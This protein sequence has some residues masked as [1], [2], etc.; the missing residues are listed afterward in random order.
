LP[1]IGDVKASLDIL[2]LLQ[3]RWYS[4]STIIAVDCVLVLL[5]LLPAYSTVGWTTSEPFKD[6]FHPVVL[7]KSIPLLFAAVIL[8]LIWGLSVQP[9]SVPKYKI[10][11]VVAIRTENEIEYVRIK[12]DFVQT[13]MDTLGTLDRRI[14]LRTLNEFHTERLLSSNEQIPIYQRKTNSR[15]MV[16][17][18]CCTRHQDG[19][20]YYYLNLNA[21]VSHTPIPLPLSNVVRKQMLEVFP[22]MHLVPVDSELFGFKLMSEYFH[23]ASLFLLGLSAH[24]SNDARLA[25]SFHEPLLKQLQGAD[26]SN[27]V[28]DV[29]RNRCKAHVI[30]E[31]LSLGEA[32]YRSNKDVETFHNYSQKV[33]AL[34]P[35]NW[36]A[37]LREGIYYFVTKRDIQSALSETNLAKNNYDGIWLY[38]IAFLQAY[39]GD[40]EQA[41]FTYR[42]AFEKAATPDAHLQTEV[43]MRD[44]L[45]IE[46]DKF[47]LYYCLGLIYYFYRHDLTLAQDAFEAFKAAAQGTAFSKWI[48][49]V[50]KYLRDIAKT[51]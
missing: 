34:D 30:S 26:K 14:T 25:L 39:A 48:V 9:R 38:N 43:F 8:T 11:L 10:G 6:V 23:L 36:Q 44:I 7:S 21:S 35:D 3:K 16:Y 1:A 40:L 50:D 42:K 31:C 24:V 12:N 4:K 51:I 45:N 29:L 22:S 18:T 27:K 37:H 46:P 32:Y 41:Y 47:Q 33:L 13:L 2:E 28:V 5:A 19:K 49:Y 17:G 15:L 20:A